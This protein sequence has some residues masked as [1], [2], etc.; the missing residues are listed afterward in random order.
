MTLFSW[1]GISCVQSHRC[2]I[3]LGSGLY[4]GHFKTLILFSF[5]DLEV[6]FGLQSWWRAEILLLFFS[7]SLQVLL[8]NWLVFGMV[9]YSLHP[10]Q[11][12]TSCWG[13]AAPK[14]WCCCLHA[15]V[16]GSCS[17]GDEA[18]LFFFLSANPLGL[19]IAIFFFSPDRRAKAVLL[20][21]RT[22]EK[23]WLH[24]QQ[25]SFTLYFVIT[26]LLQIMLWLSALLQSHHSAGGSR[27]G[28]RVRCVECACR[29]VINNCKK[30]HKFKI[31]VVPIQ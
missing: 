17:F 20:K 7:R 18:G 3:G 6:C 29:L 22:V 28:I 1:L 25:K 15:S 5:V 14:V 9:H 31:N 12:P 27:Q 10:D 16:W 19:D 8:Q 24:V 2:S 13:K 23:K 11:S 4:Q 21:I 30:E 26:L